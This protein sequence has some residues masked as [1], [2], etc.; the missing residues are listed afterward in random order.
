MK[1]SYYDKLVQRFGRRPEIQCWS[2]T[3]YR[4]IVAGWHEHNGAVTSRPCGDGKSLEAACESVLRQVDR[5]HVE[6]VEGECDWQCEAR[7]SGSE[8]AKLAH[9]H[10]MAFIKEAAARVDRWPAWKRGLPPCPSEGCEMAVDHPGEC[11]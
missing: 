8:K 10:L 6:L 9:G 1:T 7:Y 3:E 4:V 2:P 5:P 11:S